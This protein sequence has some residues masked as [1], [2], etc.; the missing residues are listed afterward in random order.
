MGLEAINFFFHSKDN[1]ESEIAILENIEHGGGKKYIYK[2]S[3][4]FWMDLEFLNSNSLTIRIALCNPE[5]HAF[6]ALHNLLLFLFSFKGGELKDM[7]TKEV[8]TSYNDEVKKKLICSYKN[9]R[10][11]F[12]EIYGDYV[13]AIGSEEF[14]KRIR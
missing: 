11:A 3:D 10:K 9:K 6:V 2:K 8:Y 12:I 13:A 7:W 14:Y 1:I 4:V 5:Q